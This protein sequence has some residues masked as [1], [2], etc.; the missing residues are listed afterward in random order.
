MLMYHRVADLPLDP[1]GLAVSPRNFAEQLVVLTRQRTPLHAGE[2]ASRLA[3]GTLPADAVAVTFD[4]GYV[5]NLGA[6]RPLLAASGVPATLFLATGIVGPARYWWDELE[7]LIFGSPSNPDAT[8]DIGGERVALRWEDG[9]STPRRDWLAWEA[10]ATRREATYYAVWEKLRGLRPERRAVA[11]AAI[12]AAV[13]A[14]AAPAATRA[15]TRAEIAEHLAGG[16]IELGAH[17]V[18]HPA[19]T[20]L[21]MEDRRAE[22]AGSKAECEAITGRPVHGFAYPHGDLDEATKADVSAAGF[23]WACSTVERPVSGPGL[24]PLALPRYQAYNLPG[25]AFEQALRAM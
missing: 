7:Q 16:L 20:T 14:A 17:T 23:R 18:T 1:W 12:R 15:M 4:D 11:M 5:D 24:D 8:I 10:P 3:A 13:P 6:A 19:L 22:I 25:E 21:S 2:F 9:P